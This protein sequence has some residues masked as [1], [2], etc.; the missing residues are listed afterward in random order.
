M[1]GRQR[2]SFTEDYKR[3]AVELAVSSGRS[4]GSVAKEL[5]L[6]DSVL[7]RWLDKVRQEPASAAWRPTTQGTPMSADQAS[8]IARLR[9]ENERLRMERDILKNHHGPRPACA[10]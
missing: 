9:Q 10:R 7:R 1:Q 4:I 6:R 2:R 3:Q 8:E 5:G